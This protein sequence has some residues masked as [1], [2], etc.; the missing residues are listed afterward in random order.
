MPPNARLRQRFGPNQDYLLAVQVSEDLPFQAPYG[1]LMAGW[2]K[3]ATTLNGC[4]AFKMHHLKGP[5]AKNRFDRLV[6]KYRVW[7]R[8]DRDPAT[9]PTQDPAFLAV[10]ADLVAKLDVLAEAEPQAPV[11]GKRGRPKKVRETE[12]SAP[13]GKKQAA[14]SK[15]PGQAAVA[16]AASS[17]QKESTGPVKSTRQR[18]T[19]GDDLLLVKFVKEAMPFR[20]KFGMIS[21]AWEEVADKLDACQEFLKDGIK[22]PIVRY[23][24][25]NLANKHRERVK[26]NNGRVVG[27]K[28]APASELDLLMAEMVELLDNGDAGSAPLP[29]PSAAVY[30]TAGQTATHAVSKATNSGS[31]SAATAHNSAVPA[32]PSLPAIPA[33]SAADPTGLGELKVLLQQMVNQQARGL[34]QMQR[35][36]QQMYELE[37]EERRVEAE[38]RQRE[39]QAE[40]EEREKDRQAL[41]NTMM[42]VMKSFLE[43]NMHMG[44]Q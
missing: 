41:T 20:A 11:L 21:S 25:E 38:R 34:E 1:G 8:D 32:T 33:T 35:M 13:V 39:L 15:T 26:R 12:A 44:V 43:Q 36:H 31:M 42:M 19:P 17:N 2:A 23:R 37:R 30:S 10:M 14:G 40:R 5:I 16:P 18:F 24:F 22:G 27:V 28:G 7:E 9:A 29:A 3:V 6:E 4:S